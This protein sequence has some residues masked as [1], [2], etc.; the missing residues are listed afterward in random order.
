MRT[1]ITLDDDL[2]KALERQAR[3]TDQSFKQVLNGVV[4]AGLGLSRPAAPSPS[5]IEP[6]VFNLELQPGIEPQYL[7]RMLDELDAADFA[8]T[9][10]R[11]RE[12]P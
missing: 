12:H 5:A 9:L 2:Y 10:A 4:R 6:M 7:K 11:K 8:E 3:K 1:T